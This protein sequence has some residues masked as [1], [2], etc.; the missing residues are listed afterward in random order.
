MG[1][2]P[3]QGS[4]FVPAAPT[5]SQF[6]VVLP[7]LAHRGSVLTGLVRQ[8]TGTHRIVHDSVLN[9]MDER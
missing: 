5:A 2:S 1:R 9:P 6:G 8:Q 4:T 7:R 3:E